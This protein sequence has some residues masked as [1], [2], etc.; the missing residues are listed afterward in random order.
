MT[1]LALLLRQPKQVKIGFTEDNRDDDFT[2]EFLESERHQWPISITRHPVEKGAKI[3][4]HIQPQPRRVTINGVT[5]DTSLNLFDFATR[6]FSETSKTESLIKFL[7]ELRDKKKLVTIS[8]KHQ[9]YKNMAITQITFNREAGRGDRLP[10][11]VVAEE[12]T[13]VKSAETALTSPAK[14]AD[15]APVSKGTGSATQDLGKKSAK[16]ADPSAGDTLLDEASL[17]GKIVGRAQ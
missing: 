3:S 6:Q 8:T 5:S 11:T 2:V 12:V 15:E 14:D 4:D 9:T 1:T 17:L 7:R 13:L 16:A 10:Y